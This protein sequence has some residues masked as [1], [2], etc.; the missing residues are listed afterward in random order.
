M[1]PTREE[2]HRALVQ[3]HGPALQEKFDAGRVAVCGLGGLGSNVAIALV[4]AGVVRGR[5]GGWGGPG[6]R[7]GPGAFCPGRGGGGIAPPH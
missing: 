7:G 1:V 6:R 4:R 2:M 5:R 3:R